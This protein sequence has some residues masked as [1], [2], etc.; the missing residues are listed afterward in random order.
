MQF[1]KLNTIFLFS[2]VVLLLQEYN[3]DEQKNLW[4]FDARILL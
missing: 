4:N 1:G 2:G 3:L